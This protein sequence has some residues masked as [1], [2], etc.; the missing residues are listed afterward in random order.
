MSGTRDVF[1]G[2]FLVVAGIAR[3]GDRQVL[4]A[5]CCHDCEHDLFCDLD[6]VSTGGAVKAV[7]DRRP[8]NAHRERLEN[9]MSTHTQRATRCD[10]N[11]VCAACLITLFLCFPSSPPRSL[12][13]PA[14]HSCRLPKGCFLEPKSVLQTEGR[15]ASYD[16]VCTKKHTMHRSYTLAA[17]S[18]DPHDTSSALTKLH[19]LIFSARIYTVPRDAIEVH[20]A[21]YGVALGFATLL[22]CAACKAFSMRTSTA[23]E[24]ASSGFDAVVLAIR[25]SISCPRV[26]CCMH[27][28]TPSPQQQFL[29]ESLA[30]HCEA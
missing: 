21:S 22:A 17:A 13:A 11:W 12:V 7:S 10:Q 18:C 4:W 25:G 3:F 30:H 20:V 23:R 15:V 16:C 24:T 19:I 2:G 27:V 6:G 14:R 1:H 9:A 28:F 8:T 5:A 29:Q 26:P